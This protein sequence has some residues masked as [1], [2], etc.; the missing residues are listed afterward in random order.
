[1]VFEHRAGEFFQNNPFALPLLVEFVL[2]QAADGT[3]PC[4]IRFHADSPRVKVA[5][6]TCSP[7]SSRSCRWACHTSCRRVLRRRLVQRVRKLPVP[8]VFW[9]GHQ[10]AIHRVRYSQRL[11]E[12]GD[13]LQLHHIQG[14]P[15][16]GGGCLCFARLQ[17]RS[18]GLTLPVA[19]KAEDIFCGLELDP[20]KTAVIIDPPRSGCSAEFLDQLD[21]LRPAR[22]VY[23]SCNPTTQVSL[24]CA[25]TISS[26]TV[27]ARVRG[28]S[29]YC[30]QMWFTNVVLLVCVCHCL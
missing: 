7:A 25:T 13:K 11:A 6:D 15:V 4:R 9:R 19:V 30:A 24:C 2:R 26:F 14:V 22:L 20:D 29:G 16:E 28:G 8:P 1:M 17:P 18:P 3:R 21:H 27:D 12:F 5:R 23:V 10:Q